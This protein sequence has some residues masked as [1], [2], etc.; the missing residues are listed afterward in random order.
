[1]TERRAGTVM[2]G[3]LFIWKRLPSYWYH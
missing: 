2:G 1:V 3:E